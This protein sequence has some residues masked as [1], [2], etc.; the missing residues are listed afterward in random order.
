M[1]KEK[2]LQLKSELTSII[3]EIG[4]DQN[5]KQE[6]S[7]EFISR[8]LRGVNGSLRSNWVFSENLDLNTLTDSEEDIRFLFLFAYSLNKVLK[9]NESEIKIYVQEY[10]T[11]FEY[12]KWENYKEEVEKEDIFPLVLE[13][14]QQVGDRIWQ[15]VMPAQ[16]LG[17]IDEGNAILYNFSTQRNPKVTAFGEQINIDK[18]KVK[19]IKE[20]LVAGEQYP[21]PIILNILNNGESS[22]SYNKNKKILT[23]NEGSVI[24]IVDGFHRKTAST[25]AL[26]ENPDLQFNW[27]VTITFLS[28]KAAHD[29]MSQKDKQKP[30]K[31]E[32]IQL[33]DYNKAENLVIDVIVDDKLSELAKIMKEDDSYIRLKK[34]LTKKSIIANAVQECYTEQLKIST[35]I[36]NIGKWVVEFTDYLMGLYS[37][38]FI[39]NPY[40]VQETSV[41]NHKNIFYGYIAL[42]AKLQN[43]K[44]WKN[45]LKQKMQSIDFNKE[46][47]LWKDFG[48]LNNNNDANKTLRSKLYK[49][50]TE[51]I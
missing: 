49:L 35:N 34:A 43:N 40:V 12:K 20:R 7:K 39:V 38:E 17:Q 26:I 4:Y 28:E 30:M 8:G 9:R 19:E 25:L 2:E 44:D 14:V 24:N 36:R 46:N 6:V 45:L 18:V 42:S 51:G 10:F 22:F 1:L 33:K 3:R 48:M 13:N 11:D 47:Q 16:L 37:E 27:Q 15:M 32:W 41:I 23:I 29:Y 5:L 21:D 31:K 50:L